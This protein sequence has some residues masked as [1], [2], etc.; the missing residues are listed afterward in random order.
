[1]NIENGFVQKAGLEKKEKENEFTFELHTSTFL[2]VQFFLFQKK[3]EKNALQ[4]NY[5]SYTYI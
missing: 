1:M 3:E 4:A 2:M 5:L